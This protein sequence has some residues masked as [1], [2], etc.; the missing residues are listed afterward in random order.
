MSNLQCRWT[1]SLIAVLTETGD[2]AAIDVARSGAEEEAQ[3]RN[4]GYLGRNQGPGK[5]DGRAR[6]GVKDTDNLDTQ[7]R[8]LHAQIRDGSSQ[9]PRSLV[10]ELGAFRGKMECK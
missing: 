2:A 3:W 8:P 6:A 4:L 7:K 9:Q 5:Y 10:I 1:Q